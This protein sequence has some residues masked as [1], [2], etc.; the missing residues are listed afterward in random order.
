MGILGWERSLTISSAVWIQSTNVTDRQT[1]GHRTTAKTALT[2]IASCGKNCGR[3]C[4]DVKKTMQSQVK[5]KTKAATS[6]PR[7]FRES[8]MTRIQYSERL[9]P[10]QQILIWRG[11][12]C[13]FLF[14]FY[15]LTF[16]LF[17][18]FTILTT[19]CVYDFHNK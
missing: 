11:Q 14:Y 15:F 6:R 8:W 16:A 4:S 18:F 1:D 7:H 10:M 3:N 17:C 19:Y 12:G 2:H 9:M 13:A 5:T